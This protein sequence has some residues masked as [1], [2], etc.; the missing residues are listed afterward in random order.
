MKQSLLYIFSLLILFS[1]K[2]E[3]PAPTPIKANNSGNNQNQTN[4]FSILTN[5]NISLSS[6][7]VKA[8]FSTGNKLYF[9]TVNE[10][11]AIENN[12][13][14]VVA[15]TQSSYINTTVN[16]IAAN[17][18]LLFL[19]AANGLYK[20]TASDTVHVNT[21]LPLNNIRSL[22]LSDSILWIGTTSG[23]GL[24]KFNLLVNSITNTYTPSNS[25]LPNA[26]IGKIAVDGSSI[27]L[28]TASGF[29]FFNGST[30]TNYSKSNSGLPNNSVYDIFVTANQQLWIAHNGGISFYN[31]GV[32]TNYNMSNSGLS[33]D[34]TRC[35][36]VESGKVYI[37]TFGQGLDVFDQ[38]I[39][40][41]SHYN[42]NNSNISNNYLSG[43]ILKDNTLYIAT[44]NG[45]NSLKVN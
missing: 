14:N 21:G 39:N 41:F 12:Q 36:W 9:S 22:C 31:N 29:S 34:L 6:N 17:D 42:I 26:S 25:T 13:W 32:F 15:Y 11:I 3:E 45:V 40:A 16:C 20:I 27:W 30:F 24:A 43:F 4:V 23:G 18:S 2:K 7:D 19:G 8:I 35:I 28:A 44:Q 38:N 10:F 37:G 1:C 5:P 33:L